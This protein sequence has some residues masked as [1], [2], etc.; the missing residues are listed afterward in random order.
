ML[1]FYVVF[2]S[3]NA[4]IADSISALVDAVLD[5]VPLLLLLFPLNTA[6]LFLCSLFLYFLVVA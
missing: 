1:C 2:R 4:M 6:A 3:T 5:D